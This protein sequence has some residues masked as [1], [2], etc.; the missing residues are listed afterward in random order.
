MRICIGIR[1]WGLAG[2][3]K[4]I[5]NRGLA[6]VI[7]AGC[8]Y[9]GLKSQEGRTS[10]PAARECY[11]AEGSSDGHTPLK[12]NP[13]IEVVDPD[14]LETPVGV[15]ELRLLEVVSVVLSPSAPLFFFEGLRR[16]KTAPSLPGHL[17]P[18]HASLSERCF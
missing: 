12:P 4:K 17:R 6:G 9:F 5:G 18:H 3:D 8:D 7:L 11:R 13:G 14:R 10:E 16:S 2:N 1:N 15:K